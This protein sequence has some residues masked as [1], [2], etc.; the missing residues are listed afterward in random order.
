[1]QEL[2]AAGLADLAGEVEFEGFAHP[3]RLLEACR[4]GT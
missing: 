4:E 1:M 3:V 2:S